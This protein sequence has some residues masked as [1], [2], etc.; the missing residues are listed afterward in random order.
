MKLLTTLAA[1]VATASA[2]GFQ[3]PI[4]A[5]RS[6]SAH[7][8]ALVRRSSSTDY[9]PHTIDMP[10]DHFPNE[11]RYA[12]HTNATFK[13]RYFFDSTYYKPGGPVYLYIG[14]ETAAENRFANLETGIIK[15]LM[16]ATDG[17]GVILE[18]RYYGDS[19]PFDTTTTDQLRFLSNEQTIADN[20]YFA[21]HATFPGVNSTRSLNSDATPWILYGGSLAG[22]QTA[23]SVKTYG[24][25]LWGGIASSGVTKVT[26]T[27]PEWYDPILKF[28]PQDCVSSINAIV[29]NIDHVFATGNRTAVHVMKAVFGLE[30]LTDDRDF[31]MTIAFPLGGPM[32]YPTNT[33]QELNWDPEQGSSDFWYFCRNVSSLDAPHNITQVDYSLAQ[34]TGGEPWINLG[35]YAN[36]IKQYL[37]PICDGAPINSVECFGTQN[38]SYWANTTNSGTRSYL[39]TTCTEGG[40]YQVGRP[41]P[42][43]SLLSRV[44]RAN[45]TQ[46]WCT[47]AFPPGEYN[48][49]PSSPDLERWNK[50]GGYNVNAPRLAHIDGDQDVWNYL[51]YHSPYAG[52]RYSLSL[53]EEELH[54][55]LLIAGAGHHWDSYGLGSLANVSSEPQFIREAHLWEIRSV[56]RW[57][58]EWNARKA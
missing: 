29:A 53:P 10:I 47:W 40:I 15:I 21:Q 36:Y 18:N 27:Y 49:I 45:Y 11:T 41:A 44:I 54:P 33:W 38:A 34:Y 13:Q 14:G 57:L 2:F 22:A 37:I 48:S 5:R 30:A 56:Q 16:Q 52:P 28:G 25:I 17:L 20:A 24:D 32:N 58:R 39:Y 35:K 4:G 55:Q 9:P 43:P 26:L 8:N 19:Y 6:Y 31:A 1:L 42:G 51:C 7:Q 23:F 3:K 46:Q 50:Y 12:P